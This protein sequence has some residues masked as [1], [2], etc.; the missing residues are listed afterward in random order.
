MITKDHWDA[1]A[2]CR[3]ALSRDIRIEYHAEQKCSRI[4]PVRASDQRSLRQRVRCG[5]A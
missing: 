4:R 1:T 5:I 3:P 2:T